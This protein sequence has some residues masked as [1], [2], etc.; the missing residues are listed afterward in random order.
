VRQPETQAVIDWTENVKFVL[1][2]NLHGGAIVGSQTNIVFYYYLS[3]IKTV[4]K[5]Y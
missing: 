3:S 2:A 5:L 1:S 4:P